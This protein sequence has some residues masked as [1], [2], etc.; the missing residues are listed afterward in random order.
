VLRR[1]NGQ[2]FLTRP[3]SLALTLLVVQLFLGV[4]AYISHLRSPN[5][6]QPLNPLVGITVAHVAC[7]AL[8]FATSIVLTLR[9]FK[10][11]PGPVHEFELVP[12]AQARSLD[13]FQTPAGMPR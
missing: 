2:N 1:H 3:A 10:V 5:D 4:A 11:L 9:V 6:P 12:R 8:V 7:G 13:S